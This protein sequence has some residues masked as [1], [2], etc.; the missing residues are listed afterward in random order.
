MWWS[1][2]TG[3]LA[4]SVIRRASREAILPPGTVQS[5]PATSFEGTAVTRMPGVKDIALN[6][7]RHAWAAVSPEVAASAQRCEITI[8]HARRR[9]LGRQ[10]V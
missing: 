10:S 9:R 5:E 8:R 2:L 4:R 1:L 3:V 7:E 6:P